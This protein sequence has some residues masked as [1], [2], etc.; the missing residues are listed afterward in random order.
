MKVLVTGGAGYIGS[1]LIGSL[2]DE[3]YSVICL[4][5]LIFGD[6]GIKPYIGMSNFKLVVDDTRTFNS[7]ILN[8][9][10]AVVDLA[11]ISQPD[12][13][14]YLEER[15]FHE[16]NYKGPVRV[17]NLSMKHGVKK[18]IFTSTCSVYGFQEGLISEKSQPNP[19]ENY[20]KTKLMVEEEVKPLSSKEFCVTILRLATVYGL[21]KKMRFDLVV[22]GM[23]LSLYKTGVI[24]VMHPGTQIRPVVHVA[25]V[26][27][28]IISVI[29]ADESE[30]NG[31]VFN[32]GSNDQNYRIYDLAKL[33]GDSV[34]KPY[35]IEW[36]GEPDTRSYNVDFTKIRKR[37][38]F[39]ASYTP[40]QGS[41]EV[42]KA[43][44]EGVIS[45]APE[46]RVISWWKT[47]KAKEVV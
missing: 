41:R 40:I 5:R 36:Y 13:S 46:T 34:G 10:N 35:G 9:V 47:L 12:P 23:T 25:D 4:D 14:G 11:A 2:L 21:S 24:K 43:L 7:E 39:I 42:Y 27:K 26:A 18:Y 45:D 1:V 33:V 3:G 8:G 17:A 16:M 30:V 6:A 44:E 29:E 15:L 32:V 38:N 31:E 22:N 28:A 20:A 37:L 19:L